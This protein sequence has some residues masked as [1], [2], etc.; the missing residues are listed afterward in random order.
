MKPEEL[1]PTLLDRFPEFRV[2][3]QQHEELWEG[4]DT[5]RSYLD[6]AEFSG[7][8]IER[9]EICDNESLQSVFDFLESM[10]VEVPPDSELAG[11]IIVGILEGIYLKMPPNLGEVN[12]F[13]KYMGPKIA[14][15]WTYLEE[16]WADKNSLAEVISAEL[17][18]DEY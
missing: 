7:F 13:K 5:P 3:W 18:S 9:F 4:D 15:G 14:A 6:A 8:V 17:P 1:M 11:L 10:L 12:P 2:R 16:S